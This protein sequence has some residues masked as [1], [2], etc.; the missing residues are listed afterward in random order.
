[1][2]WS[3]F[4]TAGGS[5]GGSA[6]IPVFTYQD[7]NLNVGVSATGGAYGALINGGTTANITGNTSAT[8]GLTGVV[9]AIL[10]GSEYF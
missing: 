7:P 2:Y 6:Q 5:A 1:V 10:R 9:S 4:V 8:Y 3:Y